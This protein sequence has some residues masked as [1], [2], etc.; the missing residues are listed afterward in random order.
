MT[1][2]QMAR[3]WAQWNGQKGTAKQTARI[4]E[5]LS[6]ETLKRMLEMRGIRV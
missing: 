4:M 2:E 6:A 3:T 5:Y 1:H